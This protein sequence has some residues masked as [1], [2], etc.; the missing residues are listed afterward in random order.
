MQKLRLLY[1]QA[2]VYRSNKESDSKSIQ[3]LSAEKATGADTIPA[4]INKAGGLPMSE[5]LTELF[6]CM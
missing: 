6:Q 1:T 4:E 5:K 3:N 2:A